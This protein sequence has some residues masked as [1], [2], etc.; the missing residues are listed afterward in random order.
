MHL[1]G[2]DACLVFGSALDAS[3]HGRKTDQLNDEQAAR[4]FSIDA[5]GKDTLEHGHCYP[6]GMDALGKDALEDERYSTGYLSHGV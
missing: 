3:Q 2:V 5:K 4:D 6:F 1:W